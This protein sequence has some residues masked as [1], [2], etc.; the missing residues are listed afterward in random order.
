MTQLHLIR[1][2]KYWTDEAPAPD[3]TPVRWPLYLALIF[4]FVVWALAAVGVK[5]LLAI[6]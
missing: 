1:G 3:P 4:G 6:T 5:S 2:G